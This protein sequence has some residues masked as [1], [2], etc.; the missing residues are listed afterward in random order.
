MQVLT[1]GKPISAPNFTGA[2]W[3]SWH[4]SFAAVLWTLW[5]NGS[6]CSGADALSVPTSVNSSQSSRFTGRMDAPAWRRS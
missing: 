2:G 3:Q 5:L 1:G 4:A 6:G